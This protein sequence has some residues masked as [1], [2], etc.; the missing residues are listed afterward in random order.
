MVLATTVLATTVDTRHRGSWSPGRGTHRGMGT[1]RA[2]RRPRRGD[3]A[4]GRATP[5]DAC[6]GLVGS[7]GRAP[8][9]SPGRPRRTGPTGTARR[10]RALPRRRPTGAT[11]RW[12]ARGASAT[13]RGRDPCARSAVRVAAPAGSRDRRAL[14]G[15]S[16]PVRARSPG[17]RP[18]G[19]RRAARARG[20][21][22][23]R[24]VR[25]AGGCPERGVGGSRRRAA[26]D[27]RAGTPRG[28][29]GRGGPGRRRAR[30]VGARP[31]RL[32]RCDL[33]ALGCA[34]RA[35]G[36]PGPTGAPTPARSAAAAGAR[37]VA[38][39]DRDGTRA[40]GRAA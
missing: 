12:D 16:P 24:R 40:A 29:P 25:R 8:A 33:P 31:P 3:A 14:P 37:P 7:R 22:R 15:P 11:V 32:R 13:G 17:R 10:A 27:L 1:P 39:W 5:S 26:H 19:H 21:R 9:G 35:S 20:P 28:P 36:V 6:S 38:R 30:A 34:P 4:R 18:R 2:G 23:H